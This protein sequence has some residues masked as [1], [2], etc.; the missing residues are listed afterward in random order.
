MPPR[1]KL[2]QLEPLPRLLS[3]LRGSGLFHPGEIVVSRAPGRLDVMGGIADY[4][5]SLVCEMPL[6][7]AAG[8]AVQQTR[9]GLIH[10]RSC[11]GGG[12]ALSFPVKKIAQMTDIKKVR[13][14]VRDA[15]KWARYPMGC[16][17]W[18]AQRS[19]PLTGLVIFID[20]DVPLGG[21]VSS[22]AAVEVATL[23]ALAELLN[24]KL[25]PME[26]AAACQYV[27]NHAVGAPCGV[28][29]QV[30]S[31]M[32]K[33]DELIE[34]LC[35][36]DAKGMPAQVLGGVTIP[37][38]YAFVGIHSGVAHEVSG[39][40]YTDTRVA[41]FMAQKILSVS[42]SP[43]PTRGCLA[44][45]NAK[46]YK[47]KLRKILPEKMTG[48]V[49]LEQ[50][51]KTNDLVTTVVP[52]R[53]YFVRDACDH[54]VLEMARVTAFVSAIKKAKDGRGADELMKQAGKWMYESHVSYGDCA[55]LGHA[56]TD[57]LVAMLKKAARSGI[58]G[59]K[60]TGGGGG[61]TVAVLIKDTQ[62]AREKLQSIRE[63][64]TQETG[65]KTMYLEGSGPG[66][67]ALGAARVK[68]EEL[69]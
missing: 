41:A 1:N 60:I 4:S 37:A 51:G 58:W 32:G 20:S 28:M 38:G 47:K 53:E 33:A 9:D 54:H 39:D 26:L 6:K 62:Q 18:I 24:V 25:S 14:L 35:Q 59:A 11:Q 50:Y 49:F 61:G 64:Y 23:Q 5:G 15:D 63:K 2:T 16:V 56:M 29:D 13:E 52:D 36:P 8:A 65:R 10:L 43:D 40:P 44:R 17:W 22:S 19:A 42:E 27:E 57:K 67:V 48:K 21:G 3:A 55:K 7:L 34:I 68:F 31:A 45:V 12:H 66:A 30:T 46:E 69:P